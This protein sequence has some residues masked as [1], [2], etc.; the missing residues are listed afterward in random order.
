MTK[1]ESPHPKAKEIAG[2]LERMSL[3][4]T[5]GQEE[6]SPERMRDALHNAAQEVL[7]IVF[8]MDETHA[9]LFSALQQR[10]AESLMKTSML[11]DT[12]QL[13][14]DIIE[15]DPDVILQKILELIAKR[16]GGDIV[17]Y[18]E[19][20]EKQE[21]VESGLS[22][23]ILTAG[24]ALDIH[25]AGKG[26]YPAKGEKIAC[27]FF[28]PGSY[29]IYSRRGAP[30]STLSDVQHGEIVSIHQKGKMISG[31]CVENKL[32]GKAIASVSIIQKGNIENPIENTSAYYG[33][34]AVIWD[35]ETMIYE[36]DE[37]TLKPVDLEEKPV[38]QEGMDDIGYDYVSDVSSGLRREFIA[39]DN[40]L[41]KRPIS[42]EEA[43]FMRELAI[44]VIDLLEEKRGQRERHDLTVKMLE[45]IFG[46][47]DTTTMGHS[48]R[49]GKIAVAIA[50]VLGLFIGMSERERKAKEEDIYFQ[51][52][53]HDAGKVVIDDRI[54]KKRGPLT[55][56]EFATMQRHTVFGHEILQSI[57]DGSQ[58]DS[59]ALAHHEHVDGSGY[60]K[61]RSLTEFPVEYQ[62]IAVADK[63][64]AI[65]AADRPYTEPHAR[66][67]IVSVALKE[68]KRISEQDWTPEKALHEFDRRALYSK[69][70][71]YC[72]ATIFPA[73]SDTD[74]EMVQRIGS[75]MEGL[76]KACDEYQYDERKGI[77][78]HSLFLKSL[79]SALKKFM[80]KSEFHIFLLASETL[81]Q[82]RVIF[83]FQI[84][85]CKYLPP[86]VVNALAQAVESGALNDV[87]EQATTRKPPNSFTSSW[88]V[89]GES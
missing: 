88:D 43:A 36:D 60:P 9:R 69:I 11:G 17:T 64:E 80:K 12:V 50:G 56:A 61:G 34:L 65:I 18:Y 1:I 31:V 76:R 62:I 83:E 46:L 84:R 16:I 59:A 73:I 27:D 79:E 71:A 67:L 5:E 3:K 66:E 2:I 72:N 47:K 53:T 33:L 55:D 29:D 22:R 6:I 75:F 30:L 20:V 63:F 4:T 85:K 37:A 15:N 26:I 51:G 25:G 40:T 77:G 7:G 10:D 57:K 19:E 23:I 52:L 35:E 44:V 81:R 8:E 14:R 86:H 68:M 42:D 54:L 32:R 21:E 13:L 74:Q 45:T 78:N 24:A 82:A 48:P 87:I 49:V 89:N 28:R 58:S 70:S 41:E 39:V 38:F